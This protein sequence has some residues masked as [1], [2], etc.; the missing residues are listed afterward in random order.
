MNERLGTEKQEETFS[1]QKQAIPMDARRLHQSLL[2]QGFDE[3][4]TE[5]SC[6]SFVEKIATMTPVDDVPEMA[7]RSEEASYLSESSELIVAAKNNLVGP[8][9]DESN[10]DSPQMRSPLG[11]APSNVRNMISAFESSL[12]QD[13]RP[14]VKSP[15]LKFQSN[16]IGTEGLKTLI[17]V[18]V[19]TDKVKPTAGG[20]QQASTYTRKG[21]DKHGSV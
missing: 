8:K 11:K 6:R 1:L 3:H 15:P 14:Y 20:L 16:K 12:P 4:L 9:L 13:M 7:I 18:E 5:V 21:G 10:S 17:F 2:T 19:K